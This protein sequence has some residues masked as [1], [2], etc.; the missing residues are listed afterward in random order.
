MVVMF[1]PGLGPAARG[2]F[3]FQF[4]DVVLSQPTRRR[5]DLVKKD[6]AGS[7]RDL[8]FPDVDL[9]AH[10][11]RVDPVIG[12]IGSTRDQS[13]IRATRSRLA[14]AKPG[15]RRCGRESILWPLRGSLFF[16]LC[17]HRG[18][19]GHGGLHFGLLG[20]SFGNAAFDHGDHTHPLM[21]NNLF[22]TVPVSCLMFLLRTVE[23]HGRGHRK[24]GPA[25]VPIVRPDHF[26]LRGPRGPSLRPATKAGATFL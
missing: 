18:F 8:P 10:D 12:N 9:P 1:L 15:G 24:F 23:P 14:Q 3:S 26:L 7:T 21:P 2:A 4:P 16:R 11:R 25:A 20:A 6:I 5:V 17:R 13:E 19:C 22:Q